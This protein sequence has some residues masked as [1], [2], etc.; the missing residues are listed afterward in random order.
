MR[1]YLI[2]NNYEYTRYLATWSL[3]HGKRF[4]YASSAATYGD[5]SEGFSDDH[6]ILPKYKQLNLYGESKQMC[7]LWA[8]E[9]NLLDRIAGLKYFNVFGPNEYHKGN[10]RSMVHKSLC[11]INE[12]GKV[13]LFKSNNPDYIDG[14][15][16][17]DFVY[18]KDAARAV[19]LA[20][21]KDLS[22]GAFEALNIGTG[23]ETSVNTVADRLV[24]LVD[25]ERQVQHAPG[26]AGDI[27]RSCADVSLATRLLGF[28]PVYTLDE[29][30]NE[31][32]D[33]L[34]GGE[35]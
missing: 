8:L 23:V 16:V 24:T 3:E 6:T 12:T 22:P 32:L 17:R 30:L 4:V 19:V 25:G 29:G 27:R 1:E 35:T 13:R 21:E 2:K 28:R 5:G 15:Q 26:R 20:L 34:R 7:D 9:H 14:G 18:V 10:M 33:W 31:Y 11:Q